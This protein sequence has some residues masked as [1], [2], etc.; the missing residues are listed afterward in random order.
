MLAKHCSF[1]IASILSGTLVAGATAQFTPVA[2]DRSTF[3][4]AHAAPCQQ[5]DDHLLDVA[6]EMGASVATLEVRESNSIARRLYDSEGFRP[7]GLRKGY[8][9]KTKEDAIVMMKEFKGD[10]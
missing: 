7:V 5:Q 3:I 9:A 4:M 1:A 6:I 10:L 8:Y 2:Q